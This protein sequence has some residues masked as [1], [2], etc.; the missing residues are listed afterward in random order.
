MATRGEAVYCTLLITDNYL[1]GA[2]V[3]AHSLRDNGTRA[4]LVAL[5][6]P[7]TLKESTIKELKSVY[8]EIIPV[9]LLTNDT[10]ANLFLMDRPDLISSFTKIELWRQTQ[11]SKIIYL[12]ADVVALRAPDELLS[13]EEDFAAVPD[14]GWP[15]IFNSGVM[16]LRPNLQDYYSLRALAERGTSFDGADQ[17]LLNTHF[18][19]WHRL[20]FTYNC[21]PSGNYQYLPAYRHF[22]STISIIHFIGSQKPWTQSRHVFTAGT[23]YYQL[24]G[25]WWATYDR[26]YTPQPAPFQTSTLYGPPK[27]SHVS[28]PF[29][30]PTHP[31]TST[32]L[33]HIPGV[34][35]TLS[36]VPAYSS[37][38]THQQIAGDLHVLRR[39]PVSE[40]FDE[41]QS[42]SPPELVNPEPIHPP[43]ISHSAQVFNQPLEAPKVEVRS[44]VP[45]YVHGEEQS[46]V[47][48]PVPSGG[49][50][51]PAVPEFE[52]LQ[53]GRQEVPH[54]SKPETVEQQTTQPERPAPPESSAERPFSPPH[55]EW[56]ARREPPPLHS[57]PE[58][59]DLRT[60]TYTMSE[61][62]DLFQPPPS[63]PEAPKNMYYQVPTSKPEPQ[64]LAQIFP[65]ESRAPKPSRIFADDSEQTSTSTG[66]DTDDHIQ[67]AQPPPEISS[68][69]AI[70]RSQ[71][72]WESYTRSNAWDDVP[73]IE[74]YVE[75]IQW[76]NKGSGQSSS[77]GKS[78][79]PKS[80]R[81]TD[82]PTEEDRP[83]LPVTPAPMRKSFWD[84]G[85]GVASEFPAAEG[86]PN[87]EDWVGITTDAFSH[88]L[89]ATYSFWKFTEPASSD[90]RATTTA[91]G[92]ARD[93]SSAVTETVRVVR[94]D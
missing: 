35:S 87:Q 33:E 39:S 19:K 56:D 21:T 17:G 18:R 62:T 58:A 94:R 54:H 40:G 85:S 61:D 13:L 59:I 70:F 29:P 81:I 47:F 72:S 28:S 38:K 4:R 32:Q 93:A 69:S 14:I 11:F 1:P 48:I 79:K 10:P 68:D 92:A 50:E 89:R 52:S 15:D 20:S 16:V 82:F 31:T 78:H 64:K 37:D 57:K 91:V 23:P 77:R 90:R 9:P 66:H 55:S 24:L 26:H 67:F 42:F 74:K 75:A 53:V 34:S 6:T 7:Q 73:G 63:Y 25:R 60:Q 65:W 45:L 36:S 41:S 76:S 2:V 3:L 83:S 27:T 84:G 80:F 71:E 30:G 5:Y 51:I 12:D 86:V 88:I 8:D 43:I 44:V 22:E 46:S 49:N